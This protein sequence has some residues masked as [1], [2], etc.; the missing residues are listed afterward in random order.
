MILVTGA[1][2]N[3]GSTVLQ[4]LLR[5]EAPV[6]GM[7]RSAEDAAKAPAGANPVIADFADRA[8]LD[9]ALEGVE[10]VYQRWERA[11]TTSRFPGGITGWKSE[12]GRR[13]SRRRSCGRRASCRT[14]QI[15]TRGP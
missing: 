3:V 12:C 6:R 11:C 7:Y 14:S 2:G 1:S 5:A 15:S 9:H 8:S 4:E 13:G 10:R